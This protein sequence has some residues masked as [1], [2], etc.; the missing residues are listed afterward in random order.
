[1]ETFPY[2]QILFT[3]PCSDAL[4]LAGPIG[5]F[6][7]LPQN[8]QNIY[9]VHLPASLCDHFTHIS[10]VKKYHNPSSVRLHHNIL[11]LSLATKHSVTFVLSV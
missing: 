4:F 3:S 1:M 10:F 7:L 11:F 2:S 8:R 6:D 9:N 5:L